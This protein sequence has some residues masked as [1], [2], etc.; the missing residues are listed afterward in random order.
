MQITLG[1]NSNVLVGFRGPKT[2][3]FAENS[4]LHRLMR[5]LHCEIPEIEKYQ[6]KKRVKLMAIAAKSRLRLLKSAAGR[7]GD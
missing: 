3:K 6:A 2:W 7:F 4:F 5:G 1:L